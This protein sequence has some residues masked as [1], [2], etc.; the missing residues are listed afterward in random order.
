ME[1]A[2]A[3]NASVEFDLETLAPTYRL[4]IGLPGRSNALAIAT[5]LG[6]DTAIIADARSMIATEELVADD[7]LDEIH[8]TREEI[9]QQHED[10][11]GLKADLQARNDELQA[12]LDKIEDERRNIIAAARRNADAEMEE[13]RKELK[14]LRADMRDASLPLDK[15]MTLQK[16]RQ[17]AG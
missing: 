8:R 17:H 1:T 11:N 4:I 15:I 2:G 12:R 13:F 10:I 16:G 5:R 7:L 14:R 6:L 9:R 3:R